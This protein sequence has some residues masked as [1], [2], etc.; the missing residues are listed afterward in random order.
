[1]TLFRRASAASALWLFSAV[2]A[3]AGMT[4]FYYAR[5]AGQLTIT[6]DSPPITQGTFAQF[7]F[8][9]DGLFSFEGILVSFTITDQTPDPD[10]FIATCVFADAAGDT[11]SGYMSGVRFISPEGFWSGSGEWSVTGGSGPYAGIAGGGLF[12]FGAVP[13]E[14]SSFCTFE[15][16]FVPAPS[17]GAIGSLASLLAVSRPRRSASPA[18]RPAERRRPLTLAPRPMHDR[19]P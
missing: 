5:S 12:A 16:S 15:G 18:A 7:I 2:C 10:D 4:D 3:H 14:Q 8:I 19:V 6:N 1:M 9:Q 17:A 11:L 13:D